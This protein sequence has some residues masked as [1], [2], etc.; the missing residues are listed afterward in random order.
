MK[1]ISASV[2]QEYFRGKGSRRRSGRNHLQSSL[3]LRWFLI[4]WRSERCTAENAINFVHRRDGYSII[5]GFNWLLLHSSVLR[6][7]VKVQTLLEILN[8]MWLKPQNQGIFLASGLEIPDMQLFKSVFQFEPGCK[9]RGLLY[10][11]PIPL[12]PPQSIKKVFVAYCYSVE[13]YYRFTF[14]FSSS[15]V[16]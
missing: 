8:E 6:M 9:T 16:Y 1:L 13:N 3:E 14:K 5:A 7:L 4:E 12:P 11:A 2:T 15:K 10:V